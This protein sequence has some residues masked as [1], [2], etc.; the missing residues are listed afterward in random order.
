M[1]KKE[2]NIYEEGRKLESRG[3][4]SK[5]KN[6]VEHSISYKTLESG[7]VSQM[8]LTL[9]ILYHERNYKSR[10]YCIV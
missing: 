1:R 7:F 3:Q 8:S 6:F 4:R 10:K 9:I 5:K 2:K